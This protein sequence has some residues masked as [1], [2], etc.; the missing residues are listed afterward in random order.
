[1]N[2]LV[3]SILLLACVSVAQTAKSRS[4]PARPQSSSPIQ[5]QDVTA[6]A[7]I[8]FHLTCGTRQKLYIMD[9]MCGGIAF[10]D[11]DQD[12]WPDI[13]LL[14]GSTREQ[15]KAG[16]SPP[17]KLYHNER[18][19]TFRDVTA[20]VGITHRG[21]GMGVAV[22]DYNKDGFPDLY[23]TYLDHAILYRNEAGQR[24][25]DVTQNAGVGNA[26]RWGTSAAWGD[27]DSDGNLDL[28]VANYVD[29]DLNNLPA[30]GSSPFCQYRG[31]KVSC[32]PR[33][34]KGSR[35]RLYHS[36]GDGTFEDVS[37]KLNIDPEAFYGLGVMWLDY[38][39]DG[40]ED[41]YVADDSSPSLLYRG[42]CKGGLEEVGVVAGVAYSADGMEQAG[43]GIDAADFD[44]DGD[45]DI[46]K[47]N[48]SDDMNN[49]YRNDG[50]GEFTDVTGPSRF[51]PVSTPLLGFG[52]R[53]AD[54][55][56]DGWPDI[57]VANGHV[58]PQVD[59][60]KFGV[61]YAEKNLLFH[62]RGDG[63]FDEIGETAGS[64]MRVKRVGRGLAV[65]DFDKDGKLDVLLSNLDGSPVL[66]RNTS[67]IK[68]NWIAVRGAIGARVEVRAGNSVRVQEIRTNASYLSS[69]EPV[70][71][72]GLGSISKV[73]SVT[74]KAHGTSDKVVMNPALN[75]VLETHP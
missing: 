75:Q 17:S 54:F 2:R 8:Q 44:G 70:A 57:M 30:F 4:R 73:D 18:N 72:F 74:V 55:D 32:G 56:N 11:Y 61:S 5:F 68:N 33:G 19:G 52:V 6:N 49:L 69:S 36:R 37:E 59:G 47:I 41:V 42:D 34:L 9:A 71:H 29:I 22:A 20:Q 1:M 12:G 53:F 43:M 46:A 63:T 62:N 7:G 48:F 28:Y 39:D 10:L 64:A 60:K 35:D 31:I 40:C 58:N 16:T 15:L 3:A 13:F 51:G 14:N 21:W 66:L 38:N 67:P 45:F 24:F 27:Y 26:Q 23:L 25:V 50:N 65:A